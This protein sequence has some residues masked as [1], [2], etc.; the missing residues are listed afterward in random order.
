MSRASKQVG[1]RI[2]RRGWQRL[3]NR[4]VCCARC[5]GSE[6]VWVPRVLC[7]PCRIERA[8]AEAGGEW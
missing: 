4:G 3:A 2:G 8:V 7:P 6:G 5:G 1:G